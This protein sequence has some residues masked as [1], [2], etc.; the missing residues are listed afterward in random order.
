MTYTAVPN[1]YEN[2]LKLHTGTQTNFTNIILNEISQA[3][4]KLEK[5]PKLTFGVISWAVVI[6]VVG[7]GS[8]GND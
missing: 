7:V 2:E 5:H 6:F 1:S 3:Q 8:R 4:K